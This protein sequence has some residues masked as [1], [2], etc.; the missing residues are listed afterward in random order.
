MS[1]GA[2]FGIAA[3]GMV[4]SLGYDV[5]MACAAARAGLLRA[6]PVQGFVT[7]SAA[8]GGV[9]PIAGH[10]AALMTDGFEGDARLIRLLQG[11]IADLRP[12][13]ALDGR[14]RV[15]CYLAIPSSSRCVSGAEL[16][17]RDDVRA[18]LER[19]AQEAGGA[20]TDLPGRAARLFDIAWAAADAG[21]PPMLAFV[22]DAGHASGALALERALRDLAD[23]RVDTALVGG[24]DSWL[25]AQTLQWL[26]NIGRLKCDAYPSGFMPGEAA[27]FVALCRR[28]DAGASV[29][30][31]GSVRIDDE[32]RSLLSGLPSFGEGLGRVLG[33]ALDAPEPVSDRA[34]IVSDLNGETHR[35]N[36]WGHALVRVRPGRDALDAPQLWM[37][38][39]S[40][41][42]VGAATVPVALCVVTRAALRGY[43]PAARAI[44]LS[45][46]D[47][48]LRAAIAVDAG[49]R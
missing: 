10:A 19:A 5:E 27:A 14:A 8:H 12:R 30:P 42:D 45:A 33:A 49:P 16:A 13:I 7:R 41:G 25:D 20:E 18:E 36:E 2:P 1:R 38:A 44:V 43:A 47:G 32:P 9:E 3:C 48:P 26:T 22:T 35:A 15:A 34:W 37:P 4:C 11:A 40:F 6:A 24:V 29:V 31:I 21:R 39:A 23:A 17:V 46:S 28:A